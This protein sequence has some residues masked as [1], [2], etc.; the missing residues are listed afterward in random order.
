MCS[1][2]N[3]HFRQTFSSSTSLCQPQLANVVVIPR[4]G[5]SVKL[6]SQ[7]VAFPGGLYQ[8]GKV[9][10]VPVTHQ[11]VGNL[12]CPAPPHSLAIIITQLES[13]VL[14]MSRWAVFIWNLCKWQEDNQQRQPLTVRL[15]TA[16]HWA[17]VN[18]KAEWQDLLFMS[19][20]NQ[21]RFSF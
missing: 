7:P 19:S 18:I 8:T 10:N 3:N 6:A 9:I 14:Q 17:S 11:L 15:F 12:I 5:H 2:F 20:G 21:M 16:F 13:P 1:I 4:F